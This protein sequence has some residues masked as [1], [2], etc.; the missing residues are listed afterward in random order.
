M[1]R[2]NLKVR[3]VVVSEAGASVYSASEKAIKEFPDMD[4][5]V[6]EP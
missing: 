3:S 6:R 2:H 1:K 5:T 4:V